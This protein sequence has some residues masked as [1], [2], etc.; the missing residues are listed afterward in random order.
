MPV[1][2]AIAAAAA[3]AHHYSKQLVSEEAAS[4][5][6][7]ILQGLTSID[8][9]PSELRFIEQQPIQT[10][11]F[12]EGNPSN[13]AAILW[14]RLNEIVQKNPWLGGCLAK[15]GKGEDYDTD[16]TPI[17]IWYDKSPSLHP[18][19]ANSDILNNTQ[20]ALFKV[21]IIPEHLC[22]DASSDDGFTLVVSM[23]N[24]FGD[25][26]TF[27]RIY[28]MLIGSDIISLNPTRVQE[29][30]AGVKKLMGTVESTYVEHI[31]ADSS[32]EKFFINDELEQTTDIQGILFEV[33]SEW[34]MDMKK[35]KLQHERTSGENQS[36]H[37]IFKSP[38][39]DLIIKNHKGNVINRVTCGNM[40]ASW[41]WNL[42]RPDV[43]LMEVNL[44][45]HVEGTNAN[46]AGNYTNSIAHTPVD[47]KTAEKVQ[48]SIDAVCRISKRFDPPTILPR[49]RVNTR[50]SIVSNHLHFT[51]P[52]TET[53]YN[54]DG[55]HLATL[56]DE[57]FKLVRHLPLHFGDA[58]KGVLPKRMSFLDLFCISDDRA[59]CF[60]VAPADVIKKIKICGI[61]QETIYSF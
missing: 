59:G 6:P 31:T 3:A 10:I 35:T 52:K 46:H 34:L 25:D 24:V 9:L 13:A 56:N 17:R 43:G 51:R 39:D 45:E 12:Y 30:D 36:L 55:F 50:F 15:G 44:R 11:A 7:S 41:F 18:V 38:L 49:M 28:D 29:F 21:S 47:Y 22:S 61:V 60:V 58:L 57:K 33:K 5:D 26:Y 23:S 37:C 16:N 4:V 2:I 53:S 20:E 40:I 8:L 14:D 48:K 1:F 27:F 42:V 19:K 32:W 54:G